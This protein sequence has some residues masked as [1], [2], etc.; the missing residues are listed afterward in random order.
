MS[1]MIDP[2][3]AVCS[4]PECTNNQRELAVLCCA[5]CG[6]CNEQSHVTCTASPAGL[7]DPSAASCGSS[8]C[9]NNQR[10]LAVLV[11]SS[12]GECGQH[13]HLNCSR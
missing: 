2:K 4:D 11:C 10:A 3:R 13:T 5:K 7:I 1:D 12:C 6:E 9:A 8:D